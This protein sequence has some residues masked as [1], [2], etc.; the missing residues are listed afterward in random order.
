MSTKIYA[1]CDQDG[2]V[3]YIGRTIQSTAR[4]LYAHLKD[5]RSGIENHRCHWIRSVLSRGFIPSLR[6]LFEVDGDGYA[7]EQEWIAFLRSLGVPLVNGTDGGPGHK[8]FKPSEE[9]RR[10]SRERAMGNKWRLGKAHTEA[11]RAI[12]RVKSTGRPK[13]A[14]ELRKLSGAMKGRKWSSASKQ[15]LSE[16]NRRRCRSEAWRKSMRDRINVRYAKTNGMPQSTKD[17]ISAANKRFA[18]SRK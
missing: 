8:G 15:K 10:K 1:L 3:R 13:T 2:R 17:K 9:H 18:A 7:E 4:R 5:A 6:V 14:A 11:T 16:T 12:L